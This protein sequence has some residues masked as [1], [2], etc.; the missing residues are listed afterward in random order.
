LKVRPADRTEDRNEGGATGQVAAKIELTQ[1]DITALAVD[2]IVNAANE[3]LQLGGGVA[4]AIRR[5]GGSSI[6]AECDRIGG[7]PTGSAVVTGGGALPARWVVHAVGPVWAGGGEGEDGLLAS[8]V[9]SA[10][11][12]AEAAG[13]RSVALPAISTGVYGFPLARAAK[14]SVDAAMDFARSA[15]AVERIVFCLF[16]EG[17][18]KEFERALELR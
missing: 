17:A 11:T 16:D 14:V 10:L 8:A 18:M 1:G 3:H 5:K 15:R 7:C 4:G 9:R 12:R 13:A 6:Q 2:A